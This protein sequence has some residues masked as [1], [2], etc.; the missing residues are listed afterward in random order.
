MKSIIIP[1]LLL[2]YSVFSQP[3]E[4]SIQIT[5]YALDTFYNGT[6]LMR[7]GEK[8]N[9]PLNYN[10]LTNEMIFERAGTRLA[11]AQPEEVDTAYI[12]DHK[13]VFVNKVFYEVLATTPVP[14]YLEYKA[15]ILKTG[16]DI[17]YGVTGGNVGNTGVSSIVNGG[18]L[19]DLHLPYQYKVRMRKSFWLRRGFNYYKANNARQVMEVFPDKEKLIRELIKKNHTDF[20]RPEDITA[21]VVALQST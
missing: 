11:I 3:Q 8:Q 18:R 9:Y 14:L 13:F 10:T 1:F 4:R 17:G 15:S 12:N 21:L 5:H 6:L 19:Y 7:S 20:S 16:N 2:S